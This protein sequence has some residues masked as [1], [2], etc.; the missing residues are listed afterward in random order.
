MCVSFNT[1]KRNQIIYIF[2]YGRFH[3]NQNVFFRTQS[4]LN[5]LTHCGFWITSRDEYWKK[6]EK[7]RKRELIMS[8]HSANFRTQCSFRCSL[9][10]IATE[11]K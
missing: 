7:E 9:S 2:I 8:E 11:F 1:E 3:W 5:V 10:Y 6:R 4:F